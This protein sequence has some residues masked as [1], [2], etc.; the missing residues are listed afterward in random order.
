MFGRVVG[1]YCSTPFQAVTTHVCSQAIIDSSNND[2]L[3]AFFESEEP[4]SEA[5]FLSPEENSAVVQFKDTISREFNGRYI[6]RLP[7]S[8]AAPSLGHSRSHAIRRYEQ[9][10]RTLAKRGKRQEF[11]SALKEYSDT[12]HSELVPVEDLSKPDSETYYLPMHG[13]VKES[14]TT[15]KLR[16]VFDSSSKSTSDHSLFYQA[17]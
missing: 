17:Q 16:F 9:K 5:E 3:K 14:S 6:V 2:L 11:L 15:N 10:Q 8:N 12:K 13:V 4:P 1:G 7:R